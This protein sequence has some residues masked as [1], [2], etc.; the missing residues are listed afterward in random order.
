MLSALP[1]ALGNLAMPELR[2]VLATSLLLAIASFV[3]LWSAL[4]LLVGHSTLFSWGPLNWVVDLLG[5]A[6]VLVLSWLLFPAIVTLI[7]G[8]FLNRVAAAVEAVDYPGRAAVR[9]ISINEILMTT[10]RLTGLIILL[11]LLALPIYVLAPGANFFV[12]LG[13]NGYLLGREYFEV[14]ALRRLDPLA[15]RAL[16]RRFAGRVF[17]GGIVIAGLFAVPLLNLAAPVIA[18]AFMV[19][20]FESL[21]YIDPQFL[22]D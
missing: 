6:A 5:A 10:L 22:G 15:T 9:A 13:L 17:V 7:M 3:G 8:L 16:R 21:R 12:F 1:R 20:L 2:R 14:V 19:H 4:A 11:N 18:T